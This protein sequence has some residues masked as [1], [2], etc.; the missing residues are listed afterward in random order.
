MWLC[1]ECSHAVP[2][3]R[4]DLPVDP[5]EDPP[6]LA[7]CPRCG[8]ALEGDPDVMDTWMTSSLTPL[9]NANWAGSPGRTAG[10]HPMTLRVQAHEIIRTWL[11]Y[12]L[13]KSHLHEGVL[14]WRDV[15]IS[16]WGLNEQGKK[17]GKRDLAQSGESA[18]G[19]S[20]NR[21]DPR[22]VIERWGAD[23]LRHWAGRAALGQNLRYHARDVKAGR[24]VAVKL[25]NAGVL[26][27]TVL[28]GQDPAVSRPTVDARPPEDRDVLHALDELASV[29]GAALEAY[30]YA[31]ALSAID[32][33]FF[34]RFCD[35]WLEGMKD[36]VYKPERFPEGSARA[37]KATLYE[38][39]RQILGL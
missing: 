24:R 10:P 2:A 7:A 3:R 38:G 19:A 5:L 35:D 13:L 20:F 12:T 28:D 27:Q 26:A 1:V 36:R 8:G 21:Y 31:T 22:Q 14:P 6:P 16:G 37:A 23:A 25:W 33:C 11:F 39:L 17:I 30:D 4:E 18:S 9:I 34:G 32:R 29:V 15:M